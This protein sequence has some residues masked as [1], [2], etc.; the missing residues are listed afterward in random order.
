MGKTEW[1][2][3]GANCDKLAQQG[4]IRPSHQSRYAT[5]I[6]V[7]RK[8]GENGAYTD[9]RQCGDYRPINSFTELDRYPLPAIEDIFQELQG[10]TIFHKLDLRSGYH[11]IPLA[12]KD[13]CKTA[14]WGMSRKL[15]EWNVVPFGL[16]NAPPFFQRMMDRVL[17]RLPSA[18]CYIDDIVVWSSSFS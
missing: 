1:E 7:V 11:Q 2:F 18:R 4:L 6:V 15:W 14:F 17:S 8:R 16:K 13:K 5:T 9:L 12:E 3:V 10:A